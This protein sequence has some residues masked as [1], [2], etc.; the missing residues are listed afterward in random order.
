MR[1]GAA[2][3]QASLEVLVEVERALAVRRHPSIDSEQDVKQPQQLCLA[4]AP[5]LEQQPAARRE[6]NHRGLEER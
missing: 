6:D 2:A 5:Q 1:R 3:A 4:R